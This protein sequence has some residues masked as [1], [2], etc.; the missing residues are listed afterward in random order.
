MGLQPESA[1]AERFPRSFHCSSSANAAR[2]CCVLTGAGLFTKKK[3]CVRYGRV[4]LSTSGRLAR[5]TARHLSAMASCS[6]TG[7]FATTDKLRT[8]PTTISMSPRCS[9][10]EQNTPMGAK[11]LAPGASPMRG[12]MNSPYCWRGTSGGYSGLTISSNSRTH[13]SLVSR[14]F[15]TKA[16]MP[17]G[18]TTRDSSRRVASFA[19][20]WKACAATTPQTGTGAEGA[21]SAPAASCASCRSVAE[22]GETITRGDAGSLPLRTSRIPATGSE[23]T[24]ERPVSSCRIL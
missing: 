1:V 23:A 10:E 20:Q 8:R 5:T 9:V 4:M 13:L 22:P 2:A 24:K 15:H 16:S 14:L 6:A 11:S 3:A 12:C 18:D 17:P 7:R 21:A 19:N